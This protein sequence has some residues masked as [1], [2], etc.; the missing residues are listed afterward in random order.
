MHFTTIAAALLSTS[1]AAALPADA[2]ALE[3]RACSVQYPT[4]VFQIL[5]DDPTHNTGNHGYVYTSQE[6]GPSHRWVTELQFTGVPADAHGCSVEFFFAQGYRLLTTSGNARL[7]FYTVDRNISVEHDTW[8]N[9]PGKV[10][11][12]GTQ[13]VTLN[14]NADTK[15]TAVTGS[16]SETMNYIVEVEGVGAG[17]V[18]FFDSEPSGL[19]LTYNC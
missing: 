10:S 9:H 13:L 2:N 18:G 14:Q 1:L 6:A 8:E 7:N 5:E 11:L 17:S 3:R 16:C 19:R 15:L 4:N 12:V